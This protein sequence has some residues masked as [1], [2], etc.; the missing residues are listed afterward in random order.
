MGGSGLFAYL[1][2]TIHDQVRHLNAK[3]DAGSCSFSLVVV[4]LTGDNTAMLDITR[5][6][7]CETR[8]PCSYLFVKRWTLERD[9]LYVGLIDNIDVAA[10]EY[11]LYFVGAFRSTLENKCK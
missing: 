4:V 10:L 7:Q 1:S 5:E 8:L 3:W 2:C 9:L 6:E 11:T